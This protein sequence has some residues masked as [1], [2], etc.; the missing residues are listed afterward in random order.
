MFLL[1]ACLLIYP[2]QCVC[3]VAAAVSVV[4]ADD[5]N[6]T[7][8]AVIIIQSKRVEF[9]LK[10]IIGQG[11]KVITIN[12]TT[13]TLYAIERVSWYLSIVNRYK[14]HIWLEHELAAGARLVV[15]GGGG[16][17][18]SAGVGHDPKTHS[19]NPRPTLIRQYIPSGELIHSATGAT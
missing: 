17:G 14:S 13:T 10:P 19:S 4:N 1:E 12:T 15:V 5:G 7:A 16:N 11:R 8:V 3:S 9:K 6:P 18:G 2:P